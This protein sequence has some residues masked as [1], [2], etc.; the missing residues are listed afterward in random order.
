MANFHKNAIP[1]TLEMVQDKSKN[2]KAMHSYAQDSFSESLGK[3]L[4]KFEEKNFDFEIEN[5]EE[6][7]FENFGQ[8]KGVFLGVFF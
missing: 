4:N 8:K 2:I 6:K 5:F 1:E 3:F 7:N